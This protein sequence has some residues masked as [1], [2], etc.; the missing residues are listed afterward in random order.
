[1]NV[2]LDLNDC[3]EYIILGYHPGAEE[4]PY[5]SLRVRGLVGLNK[6]PNYKHQI[7]NKSQIPI[8]NDQNILLS[9]SSI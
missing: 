4:Q 7:T 1:M 5:L 8:I 9:V 3:Q 6:I 2:R